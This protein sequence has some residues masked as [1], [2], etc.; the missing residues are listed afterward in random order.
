MQGPE[1][2][3]QHQKEKE[4]AK[5][6]FLDCLPSYSVGRD[7][8]TCYSRTLLHGSVSTPQI[9]KHS[10]TKKWAESENGTSHISKITSF[11]KEY[12]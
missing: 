5:T 6:K 10:L 7:P 3:P 1:R 2:N 11:K 8:H 4:R 9:R 12:Y